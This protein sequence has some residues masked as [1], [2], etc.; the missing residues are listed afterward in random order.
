VTSVD[1]PHGNWPLLSELLIAAVLAAAT[2]GTIFVIG[3]FVLESYGWGVFVAIP[4]AM[5]FVA[6]LAIN[7]RRRYRILA[8]LTAMLA[9]IVIAGVSLLA[10]ALEGAI[11]LLMALPLAVP[12]GFLGVWLG[13]MVADR[14]RGI[15]NGMTIGVLILP[16][17]LGASGPL[18]PYPLRPV[19]T[20]VTIDAPVDVVWN[21]VIGFSD[22]PQSDDALYRFGVAQPV[23]AHLD[24]EGVGAIRYCEFSTGPFVEPITHWEPGVKLAFDVT[25][26]PEPMHE[27]S[28][29]ERVHAPHL[30][31]GWIS[32]NGEFL[33]IPLPDGRTR[34]QGTTWYEM[35]MAPQFYWGLWSDNF[36]HGIHRTVLDH[37]RLLSE[38]E[39]RG[40]SD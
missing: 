39:F 40:E 1:R 19:V 27:W 10:F 32:R 12:G 31:D 16:V 14:R 11:C 28:P 3:V 5:G 21:N 26:Q 30:T 15:R 4:V 6:A 18:T 29:Y 2:G 23:R 17:I 20:S 24:G 35:H 34:L 9:G 8:S 7:W 33:L 22:L 36:I 37:V 38:Q 25:E 13:D